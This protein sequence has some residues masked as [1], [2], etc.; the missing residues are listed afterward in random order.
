MKKKILV[1]TA[2][3]LTS[4]TTM[5]QGSLN[6]SGPV[7]SFLNQ[8]VKPLFPLILGI[9]FILSALFN[10]GMVWDEQ[11]RNWKAYLTRIGMFIGATLILMAVAT[12]LG[13][14]NI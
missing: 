8:T 7:S 2:G 3:I 14:L 5:A 13:T 6:L 1:L 12:W 9:V 10:I 11:N 4:L